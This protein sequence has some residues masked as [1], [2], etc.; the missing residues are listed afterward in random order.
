M[1]HVRGRGE[2]HT[3]FSWGNLRERD[4]LKDLSVDGTILKLA[5]KKWIGGMDWL[6]TGTDGR[7][8]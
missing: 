1:Y 7:L 4:G 8:L 3:G 5:F 2:L 6:R